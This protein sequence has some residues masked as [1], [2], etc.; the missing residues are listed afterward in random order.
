MSE[1]VLLEMRG[2]TKD[3]PGVRALDEVDF[4]LRAGE[5]HALLGENGAGKSTLMRILFGAYSLDSGDILLHGQKVDIRNPHH[6]L[7]Q[8]ISMVHQELN[9]VPYMNAAQNIALGREDRRLGSVLSGAR[10]M[11]MPASNWSGWAFPWTCASRC[12]GSASPSSR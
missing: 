8:G 7:E 2:I 9:L 4:E 12:A 5:I 1:P 3:F 10:S 6:A 11:P